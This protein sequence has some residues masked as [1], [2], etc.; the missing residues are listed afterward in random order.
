MIFK[1]NLEKIKVFLIF[2][3]G[4]FITWGANF[5]EV[6]GY[7]PLYLIISTFILALF[8][9][10]TGI[11]IPLAFRLFILFFLI[12]IT[13]TVM[14]FGGDYLFIKHIQPRSI[15]PGSVYLISEYNIR[16]IEKI[17]FLIFFFIVLS[18]IINKRREWLVLA[19]SFIVGL[20]I[21]CLLKLKFAISVLPDIRFAGA[22]DDP[23]AFGITTC[24]AFFLSLLLFD[25]AR[26]F[27]LKSA[28]ITASIF[29][30]I[31]LL[32]SQSRGALV[33]LFFAF[34]LMLKEKK[35]QVYKLLVL[36]VIIFLVI[37]LFLKS[38]IPQ[39]FIT[40]ESWA[41]DRGSHRLDIWAIYLSNIRSFFLTGVGFLRG[42]DVISTGILGREFIPHNVFLEMLVEFGIAGLFLFCF[43]LRKLWIS[44]KYFPK[45]SPCSPA[46]KAIF[47]SWIIGAFFINSFIHRE[48]WFVLAL[49]VTAHVFYNDPKHQYKKE[50]L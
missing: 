25:Y 30:F 41:E 6:G 38:L 40:P 12:H 46:L 16:L 44:L 27:I 34:F 10:S 31:M 24:V 33:A 13:I 3:V 14:I 36:M 48:T 45:N 29:F 35:F 5:E 2:C 50:G 23:N 19:N 26:N 1:I 9:F 49:I 32:L 43:A 47:V 18:S 28:Y 37:I 4:F 22:Y 11:S 7:P 21:V 39:R 17:L 8:L 20:G 42:E 15:D